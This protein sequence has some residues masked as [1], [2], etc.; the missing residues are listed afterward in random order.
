[1]AREKEKALL[2]KQQREKEQQERLALREKEKALKQQDLDS[3]MANASALAVVSA[4]P[5][6]DDSF[7]KVVALATSEQ[8]QATAAA[9][10]TADAEAAAAAL[11]ARQ[12]SAVPSSAARSSRDAAKTVDQLDEAL[13]KKLF[14][15]LDRSEKNAVSKRDVLMGLR[16]HAPVRVVFGLPAGSAG[17]GGDELQSRINAIQDA[18]EAS[19]GLGELGVIFEELSKSDD[20]SSQT[21]AWDSFLA[22][23][24][25]DAVRPRAVE[26]VSLLPREHSV[27]SSF[28]ATYEW[29]VV[30]EGAACAGGLEY[31]M[32][33]ATGRTLGRLPRP[34]G[35]K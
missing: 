33:M 13:V 6:A 8:E 26:A 18:F 11:A 29:K 5:V 19:S 4:K 2:K 15:L 31:K 9:A 22:H 30:P 27:G 10:A 25:Q 32:D 3:D 28:E 20:V 24:K 1:M 14:Q 16:K 34:K 23:C 12:A 17:S 35:W 21:F 7:S